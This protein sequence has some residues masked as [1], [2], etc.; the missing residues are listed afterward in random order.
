ML[1]FVPVIGDIVDGGRSIHHALHGD[2]HSAGVYAL[3]LV[4][5]PGLSGSGVK[6]AVTVVKSA[7]RSVKKSGYK[8]ASGEVGKVLYKGTSYNWT[9]NT[10]ADAITQ[11]KPLRFHPCVDSRAGRG[12]YHQIR[13]HQRRFE[14]D[15]WR[16]CSTA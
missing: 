2:W 15:H 14:E 4:P 6:A 8:K 9:A 12:G 1:S 11:V 7:A 10:A 16:G 3:G 13:R 5:L